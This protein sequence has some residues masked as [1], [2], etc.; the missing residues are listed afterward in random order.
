MFP[1]EGRY[2]IDRGNRRNTDFM[3][4][5]NAGCYFDLRHI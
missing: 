1:T 2:V 5:L 4:G 3:S